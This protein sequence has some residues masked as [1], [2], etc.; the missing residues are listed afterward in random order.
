MFTCI[1]FSLSSGFS[2]ILCTPEKPLLPV[3]C[4]IVAGLFLLLAVS[5]ARNNKTLWTP[6]DA[7]DEMI[8]T[9]HCIM[10]I[11]ASVLG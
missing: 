6:Q 7:Y 11:R 10:Y 9:M 4:E 1:G 2:E 3:E 5:G 8:E